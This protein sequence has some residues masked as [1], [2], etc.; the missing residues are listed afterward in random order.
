M[1]QSSNIA[2]LVERNRIIQRTLT[3]LL[4]WVE[5]WSTESSSSDRFEYFRM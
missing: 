5:Q 4:F 3:Y 2:L 1:A